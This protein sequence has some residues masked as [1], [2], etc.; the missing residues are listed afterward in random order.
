MKSDA[1]DYLAKIDPSTWSRA[2]FATDSKCDL[3]QNNITHTF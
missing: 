1:H 3:L 2:W